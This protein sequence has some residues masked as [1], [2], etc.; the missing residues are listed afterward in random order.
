MALIKEF[1]AV[2]EGTYFDN[3][4]SFN[5]KIALLEIPAETSVLDDNIYKYKRYGKTND[6]QNIQEV[7]RESNNLETKIGFLGFCDGIVLPYIGGI[8][9]VLERP[10]TVCLRDGRIFIEDHMLTDKAYIDRISL[11]V[12]SIGE[13]FSDKE[14]PKEILGLYNKLVKA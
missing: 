4:Y 11:I 14:L 5:Y 7:D 12:K 2:I 3:W 9:N 8:P 13:I 6:F 1:N 10:R